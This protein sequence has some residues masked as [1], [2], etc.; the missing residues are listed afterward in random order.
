MP[1]R[2]YGKGRRANYRRRTGIFRKYRKANRKVFGPKRM[3]WKRRR[4]A[5]KR[6][7]FNEM[8]NHGQIL[9]MEDYY[10][11][12]ETMNYTYNS[13][14]Y[15]TPPVFPA[16]PPVRNVG[17]GQISLSVAVSDPASSD[18]FYRAQAQ[19]LYQLACRYEYFRIKKIELLVWP[20]VPGNTAVQIQ[21]TTATGTTGTATNTLDQRHRFVLRKCDTSYDMYLYSAGSGNFFPDINQY[22]TEAGTK[23]GRPG[24]G[25]KMT[26]R[27]TV[28]SVLARDGNEDIVTKFHNIYAPWM[29]TVQ[30]NAGSAVPEFNLVTQRGYQVLCGHSYQA[31]TI[32]FRT[33]TKVLWEFKKPRLLTRNVQVMAQP[34]LG[35]SEVAS[36]IKFEPGIEVR[37]GTRG[38]INTLVAELE[39]ELDEEVEEEEDDEK[40]DVDVIEEM[41]A[42]EPA[43]KIDLTNV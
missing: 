12:M 19:K 26:F 8:K 11:K 38:G 22:A 28:Q 40:D 31:Q 14:Q 29:E 23:I 18:E 25:V 7:G 42:T 35:E 1:Y 37:A 39:K 24:K 15:Q 41:T 21:Q 20:E 10:E 43:T 27:P 13:F 16:V 32:F 5:K 34:S 3:V 30:R 17:I 4:F 33:R 2:K 9:R 6:L 36:F